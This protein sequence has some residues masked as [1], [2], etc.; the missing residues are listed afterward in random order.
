MTSETSA[1]V[2]DGRHTSNR[3]SSIME[4]VSYAVRDGHAE[5]AGRSLQD[6]VPDLVSTIVAAFD[7]AT[8]DG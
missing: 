4:Q 2:S 1:D 8:P 3:H 7:P 6:C 5:S